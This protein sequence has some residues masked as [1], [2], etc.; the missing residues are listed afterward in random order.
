MQR[1]LI[2]SRVV[3]AV[4]LQ[5]KAPKAII[6]RGQLKS[7]FAPLLL[8]ILQLTHHA[9]VKLVL[10]HSLFNFYWNGYTMASVMVKFS[11]EPALT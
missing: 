3:A 11:R 1:L 9:V 7:S 10:Q 6:N 4:S 2:I 8:E 5:S